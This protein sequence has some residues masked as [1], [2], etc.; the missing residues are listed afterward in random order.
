[1]K[2]TEKTKEQLIQELAELRQQIANLESVSAELGPEERENEQLERVLL[3]SAR[4]WRTTF[5]GIH[6]AVCLLNP[7]LEVL[8]CNRAM[9]DLVGKPFGEI[10]GRACCELVHGAPGPLDECPVQRARETRRRETLV[11]EVGDRWINF[12]A[13]P[14]LDENDRVV[15]MVHILADMTER[16]RAEQALQQRNHELTLL[17]QAARACSSS[18][19]PAQVLFVILEEAS[20][21]LNI[22]SSSVWLTDAETGGLICR[23]ATGPYSETLRGWRLAPG[24]GIVGQ[25]AVSG[26]SVVVTDTRVDERHF[27]GV[28]QKTGLELRSVIAVPLQVKQNVIGVVEVVDSIPGRFGPTD[29]QL[30]ESLAATAA[31]AIENARLYERARQEIAQR[32]QAEKEREAVIGELE[33][34]LTKVKTLSGLL[35]ICANCKRIRN[36]QG[37]WESVEVY[38]RDHSNA[39]FSHAICPDCM[40]TLYPDFCEDHEQVER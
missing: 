20:R 34:A 29:L 14:V 13:D 17:N 19:D 36:D 26:E 4:D 21:L 15:G 35:P 24:E 40:R 3:A 11:L 38:V 12:V 31:T 5:D 37:Y 1:M 2:D 8:R 33:E 22:V 28:D 9:A 39:E 32:K 7:Q 10:I 25:V 23:D 6:D 16:K 27:K 18:L 30:I